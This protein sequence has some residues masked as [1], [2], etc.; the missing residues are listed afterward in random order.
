MH[1]MR[2]IGL[3]LQWRHH[4]ASF[5][6]FLFIYLFIFFLEGA[7][8]IFTEARLKKS[9]VYS[10]DHFVQENAHFFPFPQSWGGGG[11][12]NITKTVYTLH[13]TNRV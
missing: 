6:Y 13:R 7:G 10:F 5:F 8:K 2:P 11:Q 12:S 1:V 3:Y 4:T 9:S